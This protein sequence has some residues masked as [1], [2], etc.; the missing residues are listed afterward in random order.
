VLAVRDRDGHG[1]GRGVER[2]QHGPRLATADGGP[3]ARG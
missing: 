2:E 3:S 1:R